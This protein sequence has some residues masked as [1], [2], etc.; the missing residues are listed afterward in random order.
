MDPMLLEFLKGLKEDISDMRETLSAQSVV[1]TKVEAGYDQHHARSLHN[2]EL[3]RTTRDDSKKMF[4]ALRA[5]LE[6]IKRHVA[7]WGGVAKAFA[8]I[9]TAGTILGGALALIKFLAS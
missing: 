6:P 3:V 2:E 7:A 4:E 8:L 1:I 5:E 9:G